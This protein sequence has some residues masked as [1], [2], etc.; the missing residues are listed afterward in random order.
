MSNKIR[1]NIKFTIHIKYPDP[2]WLS[3]S[4]DGP[5]L[6]LNGGAKAKSKHVEAHLCLLNKIDEN[7]A[8]MRKSSLCK[9]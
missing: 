5:K 3:F 1:N 7:L 4:L 9:S 8:L 6:K 2:V